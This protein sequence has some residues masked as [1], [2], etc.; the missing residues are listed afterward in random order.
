MMLLFV[1]VEEKVSKK[2][3]VLSQSCT[4]GRG[5]SMRLRLRRCLQCM[6]VVGWLCTVIYILLGLLLDQEFKSHKHISDFRPP[7]VNGYGGLTLLDELGFVR[8]PRLYPQSYHADP[9]DLPV[10]ISTGTSQQFDELLDFVYSQRLYFPDKKLVIYNLDL[11]R[12]QIQTVGIHWY[13]FVV[14]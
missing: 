13:M 3:I 11:S 5:G 9:E 12:S 10:F 6:L 2:L 8:K 4:G 14:L 1:F 7:Y